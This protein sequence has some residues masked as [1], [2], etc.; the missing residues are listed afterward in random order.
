M[1]R[2][3]E[4]KANSSGTLSHHFSYRNSEGS[5]VEGSFELQSNPLPR[6]YCPAS[7][8]TDQRMK[9]F[10]V[11]VLIWRVVIRQAVERLWMSAQD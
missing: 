3:F 10:R 4:D 8:E 9:L 5:Q 1:N 6:K 7:E 2:C 11:R